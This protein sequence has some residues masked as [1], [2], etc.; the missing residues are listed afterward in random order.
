VPL[1]FAGPGVMRGQRCPQPAELLDIYPTLID[2]A[3]LPARDD[4]EGLSLVP[5]LRLAT[6]SRERPALTSHNQGNHAVRSERWRYIRYA[7]G[8]E[9]LYD[10]IADPQ[11]W[12]N[13]AGRPEHVAVIAAHRRWLPTVDVP[14]AP[15][16]AH[17]VLTYDRVS[18]TATW[19]GKPITRMQEIP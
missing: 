15:G 5:Q 18:D 17:R 2:L 12:I 16:S 11:E 9:E 7:D 3:G 6:T 13:L 19:E 14:P 4:Q 10:M 1:I 8:A